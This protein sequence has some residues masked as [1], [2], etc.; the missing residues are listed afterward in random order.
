MP[1]ARARSLDAAA[2]HLS[3]LWS[4]QRVQGGAFAPLA[5]YAACFANVDH[6]RSDE[7]L[8]WCGR[9]LERGF[10]SGRLGAVRTARVLLW[11]DAPSLPGARLAAAEVAAG[12]L[13]EQA[14]DGGWLAAEAPEP[15]R[16]RC[17]LDALAG[18]A[19]LAG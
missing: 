3:A 1:C 14:P 8:Q 2:E 10:R 11:C 5:A 6:R 9:A 13:A 15:E 19:R 17:A 12:I 18:L 7:V 16:V 4:P